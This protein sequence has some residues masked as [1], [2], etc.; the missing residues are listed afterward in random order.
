MAWTIKMEST[1]SDAAVQGTGHTHL[2]MRET[3]ASEIGMA[4][5]DSVLSPSGFT[6]FLTERPCESAKLENDRCAAPS[7]RADASM[8][9][10]QSCTHA[11]ADAGRQPEFHGPARRTIRRVMSD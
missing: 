10:P 11:D 4:V 1:T 9:V 8:C 6:N 2:K 5:A 7:L 3:A